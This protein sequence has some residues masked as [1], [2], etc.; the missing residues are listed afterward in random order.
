VSIPPVAVPGYERVEFIKALGITIIRKFSISA[1]VTE[2]LTNCARILF[3]LRTLK[4]HGLPPE[5]VHTVFQAIMMA[6]INYASPAWWG[7]SSADD[8]GRLEAFYRRCA[9]FGYCNNNTTIAS[10]CDEAD[11]R[12]FSKII[13]NPSHL[14]FLLLPP[15]KSHYYEMRKR[16]YDHDLPNRTH[17]IKDCKFLIRLLYDC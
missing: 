5:A 15:M 9:R 11:K 3:A 7:F 8:R 1:H 2:L 10:M 6:K 13:N 4:Q 16:S 12:L 14:L 17:S